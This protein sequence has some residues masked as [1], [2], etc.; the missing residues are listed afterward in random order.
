MNRSV[1]HVAGEGNDLIRELLSHASDTFLLT[2]GEGRLTFVS[3]NVLEVFGCTTEEA[4]AIGKVSGLLGQEFAHQEG[5]FKQGNHAN[6]ET[7]IVDRAGGV[8]TLLVDV[9]R[10]AS[11]EGATLF[12]C[13]D[14]SRHKRSDERN[15]QVQQSTIAISA[16]LR[17][18][19]EPLTLTEQLKR[20]LD[21]ILAIPWL[22]IQSRGSIFLMDCESDELVLSV[23]RGL[24]VGLLS[25]CARVPMG[26]C[27]C[28]RAAQERKLVFADG[29]DHRHDVQY[30]GMQDHG[31]Y[32]VPILSGDKLYGVINLYLQDGHI[33]DP[34]EEDFLHSMANTL[35]G[36]IER[37]Q[38]EE[39]IR[40]LSHGNKL[41]LDAAGDGIYGVDRL[42]RTTFVNPA[43]LR[44]TGWQTEDLVGQ[45]SHKVMHHSHPDGRPYPPDECPIHLAF[46]DGIVRH[47][48]DE[49]FWRKDGTS[50]PVAYTS[51]PVREEGKITGAVVVFRDITERLRVDLALKEAKDAA[52]AAN[53]AK[54]FFLANVSHEIRTP[55][56]A[57]VGFSQILLK[58]KGL[59]PD[60]FHQYLENIRVSGIN[61]TEIISN[62]LDLSKIEAGKVAV[63]EEELD[64]Q[65]L[66]QSLLHVH[67]SKAAE[68][69]VRLGFNLDPGFPSAIRSDRTKINQIFMNLVGNAVKFTGIGGEVVIEVSRAEDRL[70][71]LVVR[72]T[73]KG[74]PP[75]RLETIF[76]PFEQVDGSITR[77]EA[78]V[79]LGLAIVKNLARVLGGTV[80]VESQLGRGTTFSVQLPL[81]PGLGVMEGSGE[82][83]WSGLQFSS[84]VRLLLVEDHPMNREMMLAVLG[85]VGLGAEVA[86]NGLQGVAMARELKP[87]LILMDIHLPQMD[88]LSAT[89]KI[90]AEESTAKIPIVGISADAFPERR[91]EALAAGMV[92]FLVKP[93][94]L[95]ELMPVLERHLATFKK[96]PSPKSDGLSQL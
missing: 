40:R 77:G 70:M 55:L 10:F 35:A 3:P 71:N 14:I 81:I 47:V 33:R 15:E 28:G 67:K 96:N 89:R 84:D 74:I 1:T 66:V 92:D 17:T 29:L 73:G 95:A 59:I 58:N 88:G 60:R 34:Q 75:D 85:E 20:A 50:F 21:L 83:D 31:H 36:L 61:L 8:R 57:I 72:D 62:V 93:V 44:M 4:M 69:G 80:A 19:L 42:G 52:E 5:P 87:H 51:T 32:C 46:K 39:T 68:K 56:N 12:V 90:Q 23:Q 86:E 22:A 25:H 13:R 11:M 76:E 65:L 64:L 82:P 26:Y 2:D 41:L 94:D 9:R 54:S 6:I 37:K 45:F 18:A 43:S 49:V 30:E 16:L 53:R 63:V 27:L 91:R 7:R 24:N 78:G 79:G 38:A 48:D